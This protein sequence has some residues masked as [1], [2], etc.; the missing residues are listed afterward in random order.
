MP[1][2]K[3]D[4]CWAQRGTTYF[5][6]GLQEVGARHGDHD[7]DLV[8]HIERFVDDGVRNVGQV[9]RQVQHQAQRRFLE[10]VKEVLGSVRELR[11]LQEP[12]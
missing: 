7:V 1:H 6:E 11:F 4:G 8:Y 2:I 12:N 3:N 10:H 9:V 5:F